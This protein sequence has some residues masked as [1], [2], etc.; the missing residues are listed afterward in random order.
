MSLE[1]REFR[2]T[3]TSGSGGLI[4]NGLAGFPGLLTAMGGGGDGVGTT[5]APPGVTTQPPLVPGFV[6][7]P[8]VWLCV[9]IASP[10][11]AAV[12]SPRRSLACP[13]VSR[14]CCGVRVHGCRTGVHLVCV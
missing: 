3:T 8:G 9:G 10:R 11:L 6:N 14:A 5:T 1:Q 13:S 2:G 7:G 12:S 4:D